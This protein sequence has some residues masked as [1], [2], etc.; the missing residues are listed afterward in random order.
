MLA[1]TS[2]VM[3]RCATKTYKLSGLTVS[4]HFFTCFC[5]NLKS[6]E[7]FFGMC[8]IVHVLFYVVGRINK[9]HCEMCYEVVQVI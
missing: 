5:I 6:D 9:L 1:K 3:T 8:M 4:G 2:C 7:L